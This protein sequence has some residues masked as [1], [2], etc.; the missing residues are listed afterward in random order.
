[1]LAVFGPCL[2]LSGYGFSLLRH[3]AMMRTDERLRRT[4]EMLTHMRT[5][6]MYAW[7]DV[8]NDISVY[9]ECLTVTMPTT[10]TPDQFVISCGPS[11]PCPAHHDLSATERARLEE[12]KPIR[13]A[14]VLRACSSAIYFAYPA[15]MALAIFAA[16]QVC[17]AAATSHLAC[18]A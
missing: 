2:T 13:W 4:E 14:A 15:V 12:M 10:D 8:A 18:I 9:L 3:K 17:W 11:E 7:E 16:Y 6:K 1:V 5:I